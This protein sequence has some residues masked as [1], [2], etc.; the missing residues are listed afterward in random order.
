MVTLQRGEYL[1]R[2][3][4]HIIGLMLVGGVCTTGNLLAKNVVIL[5]EGD[6]APVDGVTITVYDADRDSIG[7]YVSDISGVAE[8]DTRS[9]YAYAEHDLFVPHLFTLSTENK[10]D[11]LQLKKAHEIQEL[12]VDGSRMTEKG[13][14]RSYTIPR[15]DMKRYINVLQALNELPNLVVFPDNKIY[16]QG[17]DKVK[18]LLNGMDTSFEEIAALAKDD[19]SRINLYSTPP[20]RY[21]VEGYTSVVDVITKS[22]LVGGNASISV[23]QAPYP[24]IGDNSAAIF[25]NYK[26]SRFSA[27]YSNENRH[28]KPSRSKISDFLDYEYDGVQYYKYREGI[29]DNFDRDDNKL[30]LGYITSDPESYTYSVKLTGGL[31]R[32]RDDNLQRVISQSTQKP[33]EANNLLHTSSNNIVLTNYFEKKLGEGSRNG[34]FLVN[35]LLQRSNSDY[36]SEYREFESGENKPSVDEVSEYAIQFS[37]VGMDAVYY[38]PRKKWGN[39]NFTISEN[40]SY[41]SYRES[42]VRNTQRV[43]EAG[44]WAQYFNY[45]NKFIC[46][47]AVGIQSQYSYSSLGD[48]KELLWNPGVKA[49]VYYDPV[50]GVRLT[51]SYSFMSQTPRIAQLSQ[52]YQWLDTRLIFHGNPDLHSYTNHMVSL[53][54]TY[55]QKYMDLSFNGSFNSS[56]GYIC[57]NFQEGSGYMLETLVNLDKYQELS[58]TISVVAKPLGSS[59]WTLRVTVG[60]SVLKGVSP[61]YD[62]NGYRFQFMPSTAVNLDKWTFYANYQYPGKVA[63]GQLIRPRTQYW[64]VGGYYRPIENLSLGLS[65]DCPFGN[66]LKESERTVSS[67]PVQT[68][69][70]IINRNYANLVKFNIDWNISFG[71][72]QKRPQQMVDINSDETGILRK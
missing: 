21:M 13:I 61:G 46:I 66:G 72:N 20:P 31:S 64:A 26:R 49:A 34:L 6:S 43:N 38:L 30:T 45:F 27:I 1:I 9:R 67:S 52:T 29:G 51:A 11:T 50:R 7:S 58:G 53:G 12:V 60:G 19:I 70:E 47:A 57:E 32:E 69:H 71:K 40:Y 44:A 65:I 23:R 14:Y 54:A 36:G 18:I 41:S 8:V 42:A 16:Y 2:S 4:R 48:N 25:Y 56:P 37:K 15:S 68:R 39:L 62:W 59:V 10:T 55:S 63:I 5:S 22:S 24:L 17:E 33:Y 3:L 35:L 28:G